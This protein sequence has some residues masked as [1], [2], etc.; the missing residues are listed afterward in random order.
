MNLTLLEYFRWGAGTG[1]EI[2][3]CVLV[4]RRGLN[5]SLPFFTSY[6]A[7]LVVA[8]AIYW[9]AHFLLRTQP[10]AL[11]LMFWII[12]AVLLLARGAMVAEICRR[13]LE[14]YPGIWK[15]CRSGL[16]VIAVV[17]VLAAAYQAQKNAPRIAAV[18]L[19][20]ERGLEL[21]IV[22]ILLF[23]VAFCRYY[24]VEVEFPINWIAL[25][26]GFYSAVQVANN[27]VLQEWLLEYFPAWSSIRLLSFEFVMAMWCAILWKPLPV[28]RPAP[29]LL[30]RKV[31][32]E[33][34]PEV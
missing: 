24:R 6:F 13:A 30:G 16:A 4:F 3:V 1:L 26:L 10:Y 14:S 17:L 20:T 19:T 31:Y 28:P 9:P 11:F 12:Q 25:G 22:G 34:S 32:D 33:V 23:A 27:S 5:R 29:V 18:V 8:E 7:L 15:L 21:A 2:L